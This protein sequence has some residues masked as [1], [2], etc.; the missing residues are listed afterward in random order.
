MAKTRRTTLADIEAGATVAPVADPESA[1][2]RLALP[3][4][5]DTA[6]DNVPEKPRRKRGRPPGTRS[7]GTRGPATSKAEALARAERAEAELARRSQPD[8]PEYQ[9]E[10]AD[11]AAAISATVGGGVEMFAPPPAHLTDDERTRIGALW[12]PVLHPYLG[13]LGA[14]AP[15]VMAIIGTGQ[16]VV[17]KVRAVRAA[18]TAATASDIVPLT[19]AGGG[20]E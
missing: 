2:E 11:L 5:D 10:V 7:R 16:I 1:I 20:D 12:A 4:I 13:A 17:G 6:T 19:S 14:A 8:S 18:D 15:W 3:E 9:Q